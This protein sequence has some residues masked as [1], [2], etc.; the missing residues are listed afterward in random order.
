MSKTKSKDKYI[1]VVKQTQES[2]GYD[3]T[4]VVAFTTEKEAEKCCEYYNNEY[5][6]GDSH[7]YETDTI[8]LRTK[9]EE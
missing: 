9:W 7:Y 1:C 4:V 5:G 2:E 3:G 8:L 6:D